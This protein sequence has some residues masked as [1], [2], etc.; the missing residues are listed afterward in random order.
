MLQVIGIYYDGKVHLEKV[1]PTDHPINVVVVFEEDMQSPLQELKLS[2]F[3]YAKSRLLL[4]NVKGSF[5]D[6]V[7]ENRRNDL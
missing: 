5:S 2:D 3:S 4:K 7:I 6:S 1:F